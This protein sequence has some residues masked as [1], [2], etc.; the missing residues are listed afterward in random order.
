M[1]RT[2]TK[3]RS[4]LQEGLKK[5]KGKDVASMSASEREK[6]QEQLERETAAAAKKQ[7]EEQA[8]EQ[9][10]AGPR[11]LDA[12]AEAVAKVKAAED[13][14]QQ[15]ADDD[16]AV[17]ADKVYNE[18]TGEYAEREESRGFD[19]SADHTDNG[20]TSKDNKSVGLSSDGD[21]VKA[22]QEGLFQNSSGEDIIGGLAVG[23]DG[24]D[25]EGLEMGGGWKL[26]VK[27]GPNEQKI[28]FQMPHEYKWPPNPDPKKDGGFEQDLMELKFPIVPGVTLGLKA[29]VEGGVELGGVTGHLLRRTTQQGDTPYQQ[30]THWE[31]AGDGAVKADIGTEIELNVAA[32][33][34]KV[35][36]IKAGLRA[37]AG[38]EAKMAANLS[39][40]LDITQTVPVGKEKAQT[41]GKDGQFTLQ[42]DGGGSVAATFG[43]FVGFE[44]VSMEGDLY[45]IEFVKAP[46]ADLLVG[47]KASM[48]WSGGS[49]AERKLTPTYGKY[50]AQLDWMFKDYFKAKRLDEAAEA[51]TT[52][53]AERQNLK[54]LK[55][56]A[57][58]TDG[59]DGAPNL[60][61]K[62]LLAQDDFDQTL[63]KN[64]DVKKLEARE[65]QLRELE[66]ATNAAMEKQ[67]KRIDDKLI[68][69]NSKVKEGRWSV[70]NSLRG[71]IPALDKANSE[72]K[73]LKKNLAKYQMELASIAPK[74]KAA[75]A[76]FVEGL[77]GKDV[78]TLL[79]TLKAKK[80]ETRRENYKMYLKEFTAEE[81][82]FRDRSDAVKEQIAA[83]QERRDD[84]ES[85][86]GTVGSAED[87]ASEAGAHHTRAVA[88][89]AEQDAANDK[90]QRTSEQITAKEQ[91][92]SSL[93]QKKKDADAK[94]GFLD[95]VFSGASP[96]MTAAKKSFEALKKQKK[97]EEADYIKKAKAYSAHRAANPLTLLTN[98]KHSVEGDLMAK[99]V[100][101]SRLEDRWLQKQQK[102]RRVMLGEYVDER[103]EEVQL[104]KMAK[105]KAQYGSESDA[106]ESGAQDQYADEKRKVE[107]KKAAEERE[108]AEADRRK[109]EEAAA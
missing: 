4:P 98:Q 68:P 16:F 90:V 73:T 55:K 53:K 44:V 81:A 34:P 64:G 72:M 31:I 84:L 28:G 85:R 40:Q 6:A 83:L 97:T 101:L 59:A 30:V 104:E 5:L 82:T 96:E 56:R 65:R 95:K 49:K 47:G 52:T 50:G 58:T 89:K 87:E 23:K 13:T 102:L 9:A 66:D 10:G 76:K 2:A 92:V 80:Q 79:T 48:L 38:A 60:S 18:E 14:E 57:M 62:D 43:A 100:G 69:E 70:T 105:Y 94:K 45:A 71:D 33:V 22:S 1:A 88:L 7:A 46:I 106:A 74:M 20:R 8:R 107:E 25:L 39:G 19:L 103:S 42:L 27:A 12:D 51:A 35:A 99:R 32:G 86:L 37:N 29:S 17:S 61:V 108:K 26:D 54:D 36:E 78:D 75:R 77:Q 63:I 24:V 41:I 93:E 15:D 21:N 109:K 91:E 67:Q 11:G 3:E